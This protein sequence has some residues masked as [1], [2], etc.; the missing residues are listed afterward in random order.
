[1][2]TAYVIGGLAVATG[3]T[4]VFLSALYALCFRVKL[5]P[6]EPAPEPL[7]ALPQRAG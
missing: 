3:L 4:L 6:A 7:P 1:M 5:A 2:S